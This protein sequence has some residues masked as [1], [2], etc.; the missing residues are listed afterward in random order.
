MFQVFCLVGVCTAFLTPSLPLEGATTSRD[1]RGGVSMAAKHVRFGDSGRSKLVQGI[2]LVAN[3]V[4]VRVPLM[5]T[6]SILI[7]V[8]FYI[9]I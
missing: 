4:K 5:W 1:R 9:L 7:C 6:T 8:V 2:N 3:A